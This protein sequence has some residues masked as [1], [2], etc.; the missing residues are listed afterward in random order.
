[1]AFVP[2]NFPRQD[3]WHEWNNVG[4]RLH[5]STGGSEAGLMLFIEFSRKDTEAFNEAKT[6]ARWG[7]Y[8][9]S[10]PDRTGPAK[11]RAAAIANG[12]RTEPTHAVADATSLSEARSEIAGQVYNFLRPNVYQLYADDAC[13]PVACALRIDTGAGKST[14]TI[15]ELAKAGVFFHYAVPTRKLAAEFGERFHAEGVNVRVAF[16]RDAPDP[17]SPGDSMCLML[18]KVKVAVAEKVDVSKAC[19]KAGKA[20]CPK[21]D[22]C[23]YQKQWRD[24]D[25]LHGWIF[26]A[27]FV[28][29]RQDAMGTPGVIVFDEGFWQKQL[30]GIEDGGISIPLTF[31]GAKLGEVLDSQEEDGPLLLENAIYAPDLDQL[32]REHWEMMPDVPM[33]PEMNARQLKA[34]FKKHGAALKR[35]A[36]LHCA[37]TLLE[38]LRDM[39]ENQIAVSGRLLIGRDKDDNRTIDWRGIATIKQQFRRR[40]LVLDATLPALD[41]VRVSHPR[42]KKRADISVS[43]PGSVKI[44]QVLNAPTSKT[45]L[46]DSEASEKHRHEVL[47]YI[48]QRW[49]ET[50][51]QPSLV[52]TYLDYEDWLKDK[53]PPN[54]AV[55]H[56]NNIAG[57]DQYRDIRLLILIGRAQPGPEAVETIAATLSGTMPECIEGEE[58]KFTRYESV[59]RGIRLKDGG[60]VAVM[61]DEHPD[62]LCEAVR[63]QITEAE[64]IQALGRGRAV[65]RTDDTRLDID[66]VCDVV[67]P[68]EVGSTNEWERP[69][70]LV[71]TSM[72]GVMLEAP[73]DMVKLWPELWPNRQAATRGVKG[74]PDLPNFETVRYQLKGRNQKFRVGR[75]DRSLITDPG[76][77]LAER[78]GPVT[79]KV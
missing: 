53:L 50:G 68:I 76:A 69:S 42:V 63:K 40:A 5:A 4:L 64:L 18:E 17:D 32:I 14:I 37:I 3:R 9:F 39:I 16:G 79:V 6:R 60:G 27:D 19:C 44:R 70:R 24:T 58:G 10:P 66:I 8:K 33:H 65:N 74:I 72:E 34:H 61:G 54:V 56:Y 43:I 12:W 13:G 28:F 67:L 62:A 57:V 75:F 36:Y 73:D 48:Q 45:K 22:V 25:G 20:V 7:A 35:I 11:L 30:R 23:G 1:M 21:F 2:N 49:I 59:K 26:S 71:T 51:R 46:I 29:H 15:A 55:E 47:R 52:I 78:L 31:A 38:E 41:I 77:W